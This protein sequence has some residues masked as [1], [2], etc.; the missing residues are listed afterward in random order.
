MHCVTNLTI[1]DWLFFDYF[2]FHLLFLKTFS[3]KFRG[4]EEKKNDKL[5]I[6]F[7]LFKFSNFFYIFN[8]KHFFA[9]KKYQQ[10]LPDIRLWCKKKYIAKQ[11]K[12]C[13]AAPPFGILRKHANVKLF[14]PVLYFC[15]SK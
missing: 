13:K 15:V 5:F 8:T 14:A 7:R 11:N 6:S 4:I 9:K 3:I 1:A 10:I 2:S 12:K